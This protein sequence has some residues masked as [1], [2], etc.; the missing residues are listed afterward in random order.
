MDAS[1]LIK[2]LLLTLFLGWTPLVQA[3]ILFVV[4]NFA[5]TVMSMINHTHQ[6]LLD[7]VD[8]R[9]LDEARTIDKSEYRAVV[10]VGAQVLANWQ[11]LALPTVAVLVSQQ[12][13][14]ESAV[15]LDSAIYAEPSLHQ[16][17]V[18]AEKII[19]KGKK[20]GVLVSDKAQF[21]Q[22][23]IDQYEIDFHSL[24]IGAVSEHSSLNSTLRA[25]LDKS[26][27]L[28]GVY[29]KE[30]YSTEN[31]KNILITAYRNDQPL[32]GPT[33]A[34]LRAGAIAS[35]RSQPEDVAKRLGEVIRQGLSTQNWPAPDYNPYISVVVNQQI[36]RSLN[37]QVA[38]PK[39]LAQE[40]MA[41][42]AEYLKDRDRQLKQ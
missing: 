21:E 2:A 38:N 26:D 32:I 18:L 11:E 39:Q 19:G 14:Q 24:V 16:Q 6:T 8:V 5:P 13:V 23:A 4:P 22:Q 33:S 34:Y 37:L 17:I 9:L 31:I 3:T 15:K 10:L 12:Q 28:V 27:V 20:I 30:L 40:V 1:K 29:D 36:A 41:E 7:D 42:Q 35:V 25:L